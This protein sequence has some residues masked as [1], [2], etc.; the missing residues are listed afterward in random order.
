MRR[1]GIEPPR[2]LRALGPQ[3]SASTN[4]ATYAEKC[5]SCTAVY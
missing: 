4:S 1:G 3:P 2:P 5:V